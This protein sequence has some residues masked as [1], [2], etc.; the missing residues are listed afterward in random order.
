MSQL[1]LV[2]PGALAGTS[3]REELAWPQR[4]AALRIVD[5]ATLAIADE[6]RAA[7]KDLIKLA[8]E[9]HDPTCASAYKTWQLATAERKTDLDPLE[10][11]PA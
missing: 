4:A 8:H 10:T 3:A 11:A 2:T 1:Q 9:R 7:V 5:V 6:E